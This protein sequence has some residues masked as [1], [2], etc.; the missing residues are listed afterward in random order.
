MLLEITA[1][2]GVAGRWETRLALPAG[3]LNELTNR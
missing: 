2:L 1:D 3:T